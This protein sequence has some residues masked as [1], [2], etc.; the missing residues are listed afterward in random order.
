MKKFNFTLAVLVIFGL[1]ITSCNETKKEE[2]KKEQTEVKAEVKGEKAL[3]KV[4][5]SEEVAM[6]VYAC[7]MKCEGDKTYSEEG[8]C[9]KCNM[10]LKKVE[11]SHDDDDN[12]KKSEEENHDGHDHD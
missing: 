2:V 10:D 12:E 4:T 3:E 11:A 1:A 8:S 5:E 6:A 9:P 7:P